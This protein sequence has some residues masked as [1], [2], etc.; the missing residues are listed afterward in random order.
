MTLL[1]PL[2][3]SA[4]AIGPY[5]RRYIKVPLW[6]PQGRALGWLLFRSQPQNG[7]HQEGVRVGVEGG[8]VF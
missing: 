7:N 4:P 5:H 8:K 2:W 6:F 3:P 1:C